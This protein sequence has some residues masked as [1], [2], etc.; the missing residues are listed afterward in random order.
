VVSFDLLERDEPTLPSPEGKLRQR[1]E[2]TI[3]QFMPKPLELE[4]TSACTLQVSEAGE[5][6]FVASRFGLTAHWGLY[7]INGRGEWVYYV[8]KIPSKPTANG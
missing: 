2:R 7:S 3:M 4:D 1:S 5:K 6:A 8:E